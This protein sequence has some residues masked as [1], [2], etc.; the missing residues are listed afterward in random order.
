MRLIEVS[1]LEQHIVQEWHSG[2]VAL[3][4]AAIGGNQFRIELWFRGELLRPTFVVGVKGD[5]QVAARRL[6]A[7]LEDVSYDPEVI[8]KL[9]E[10]FGQV[11]DEPLPEDDRRT[12]KGSSCSTTRVLR[13]V[14][15][16]P[17]STES[18]RIEAIKDL[19]KPT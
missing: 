3:L 6:I 15:K 11:H 9:L 16:S 2:P 18:S 7:A 12:R 14:R 5:A 13:R 1:P 10:A 17:T 8:G 4:I 19:L